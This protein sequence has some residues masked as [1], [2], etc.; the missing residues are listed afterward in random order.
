MKTETKMCLCLIVCLLALA[1]PAWAWEFNGDNNTE[2]WTRYRSY[3]DVNDGCLLV[4][5]PTDL[6]DVRITSPAGPWD[7][8]EIT[9]V[10]FKMLPSQDV[11]ALEGERIAFYTEVNRFYQDYTFPGDPTQP[12]VVYLE[13][14]GNENWTGHQISMI[15]I[16][17]PESAPESYQMKIDWI[18]MEGLYVANES[19]EYWDFENDKIMAWTADAGYDFPDP[20]E[21][22]TVNSRDYAAVLNG[23]GTEQTI[24]QAIKGSSDMA[25]GQQVMLTAA[26]KV[27]TAAAANT[28]ITLTIAENGANE[29]TVIAVDTVDAYFEGTAVYTLQQ[30]AADRQSL[31]AQVTIEAP[32]GAVIYV[33][34]VFVDVVA[35]AMEPQPEIQTGWPI[36]CVKLAEGQ[37][38]TIDGIVTPEEY[39]GAQT[40]VINAETWNAVDPYDPNL[41]H[42]ADLFGSDQFL[43][44][45]V[46]DF[47]GTYYIMWDDENLYVAVTVQDD[48]YVFKG[49]FAQNADC[50]QFTLSQTPD[51]RYEPH[52][53]IPT[54]APRDAD[55]NPSG[56]NNFNPAKWYDYDLFQSS[57]VLY[58]G[59]VDDE[60][61]DWSAELKIPWT[62]MIGDF[63][64]D[65][66]K[67]DSDGDGKNVFP[68]ALGDQ[69]G[70]TIQVRDWD[71]N[72]DGVA[73][74]ELGAQN[75]SWCWPW[76]FITGYPN[77]ERLTFVG[78]A[79]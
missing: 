51:D 18:R 25:K 1:M 15:D 43:N 79:E 52:Q 60:T 16:E 39:A 62:E 21:P 59:H 27:P 5:A 26:F 37:E 38:I 68:P 71:L 76:K 73:V 35:E 64:G 8:N 69:V 55:G 49:P 66:V 28:K 56:K 33:D 22:E 63:L 70:F 30:E 72:A 41:T 20:M 46:E 45:P 75:H 7:G 48:Q 61:Q 12:A 3:L 42:A 23:T 67:G 24:K 47:N 74:N 44:T 77:Q 13:M 19:F 14:S 29:G 78:P 4:T 36:N 65:L 57:Y 17:L 54:V 9:G 6:E 34:D 10:Y 58:D 11:S 40:V 53:Y 50:L 32:S 31:E 2:G